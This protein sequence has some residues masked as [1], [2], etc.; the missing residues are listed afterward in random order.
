[1]AAGEDGHLYCYCLGRTP[2]DPACRLP[3]V[4]ERKRLR[5]FACGLRVAS[6]KQGQK[7]KP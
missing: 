2:R 3:A 7:G 4:A 6:G 5:P 1:M